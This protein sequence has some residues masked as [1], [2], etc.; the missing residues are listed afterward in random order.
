MEPNVSFTQPTRVPSLAAVDYP[1]AGR[2]PAG[3]DM[4]FLAGACPLDRDRTVPADAGYA[5]QARLCVENMKAV[6]RENNAALENV[7][8]TRILVAAQS[9][10]DLVAVWRAVREAFGEHNVPSTLMGVALLG[11]AHQLVE[12]EAVAAVPAR[13]GAPVPEA[14]N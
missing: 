3:M 7:A 11:Y 5:E 2:I 8:Y 9:R 6:L 12:I 1:Y 14:D 13:T 4:L 10:S